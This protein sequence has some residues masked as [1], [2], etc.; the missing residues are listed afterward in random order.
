MA[1]AAYQLALANRKVKAEVIEVNEFPEL[2]DH[3]G[4]RSVPLTVIDERL[5]I[6]GAVEERVLVDQVVKAVNSRLDEPSEAGGPTS[7]VT[8]EEPPIR[9]GGERPSGLIIP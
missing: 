9:R 2:G 7:T 1:R 4:V 3:Y 6:S 5:T 8:E